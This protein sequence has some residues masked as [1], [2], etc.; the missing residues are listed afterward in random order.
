[1][2]KLSTPVLEVKGLKTYFKTPRGIARAV[3]GVS[4]EIPRGGTFAL[5][6]ESGCG[7]SITALS[8][9]Q[10]V[11]EPAGF[12][13]GGEVILNGRDIVSL[14]EREKRDIRGNQVSMIFQEPMT[15]LNPVFTIGDQIMETIVLHQER[16]RNA[17]KKLAIEMLKKVH[18]PN[19][20]RI[21]NEYPHRL[22]GGQRQRVMIAMALSCRPDLLIADEPTTALDVTIQEEILGLIRELKS[23]MGTAVLLITHNMA[24]VYRNADMVGV[25]YAGK[26]VELATTKDL[27][28]NP[29]HPYTIKLLRSIPG[30]EKRGKALDTIA[31]AVPSAT[32][33]AKGCHFSGRCPRE[34]EGCAGIEPPLAEW[35]P[36]QRAACH[37][38]DPGFMSQPYS[39]PLRQEP[40]VMPVLTTPPAEREVLLEVKGLKT[41]YPVRKGLLK[42]V[43]GH[44]KAVDGI[45]L[46]IKKGS[47]LALVGESGCGKTT[48]GKSIVQLI[49]PT[50]GEILFKGRDLTKLKERRLKPYR[51]ALQIIFQ[52]P[53]SSL[54]PRL[55]VKETIEEG[56]RAVKPGMKK[57]ERNEKIAAVLGRVGLSPEMMARY[58][59]EFS[60]GQRQRIGIARALAVDPEFIVCDEAVSALDVSV[61][62]QILNLLKSIQRDFGLSFLFI[63]HDLGVVEY[64]ADEVAV[65]FA[66]EIVERGST[67]EI[68]SEPKHEYTKKLLSAVPRIDTS[69]TELW[70]L[71]GPGLVRGR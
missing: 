50:A 42:R 25:M 19:P 10:L 15:S 27:F 54:N 6:G 71:P 4:F 48:A 46:A 9:I 33:Y 60:G 8:L 18:L 53:Y 36:G 21:F 39:K 11:P 13:A 62:A 56:L 23:S 3:D 26:L 1:M 64:I 67:S 52:D 31:G 63:T 34:M 20:E 35:K 70:R 17:A 59:H 7:K 37:L 68:F 69:L 38:Y 58:P 16:N 45:D 44:V 2:E 57:E 24:L 28:R 22:S 30:Q 49:R 41:W 65:M 14:N 32:A 12:I 51:S 55:T 66:G 5:V 40:D 47:T 29:L 43:A 61:Q